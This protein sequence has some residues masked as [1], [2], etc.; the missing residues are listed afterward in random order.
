MKFGTLFL[1][2]CVVFGAVSPMFAN[3]SV[4]SR[5][6]QQPHASPHLIKGIRSFSETNGFVYTE[7]DILRTVDAGKNWVNVGPRLSGD[8]VIASVVFTSEMSIKV[9]A[10]DAAKRNIELLSSENG[11]SAWSRSSVILP[12]IDD[13]EIVIASAMLDVSNGL[14]IE[15]AL[16]T[17]SN[18][19]GKIVY[20][21]ADGETW[22][23]ASRSI[24]LRKE[25]EPFG[26]VRSGTWELRTD[27]TCAG[28]KSGCVQET[29]LLINGIDATPAIIKQ[30]T[31]ETKEAANREAVP[32]FAAPGG[33]TRISLNRGFDKCT[34]GT[35]SQMQT[36]WDNSFHHNANIYMSGRNRACAQPQLTAAWVE[37]VTQM[38]WGLIPTIVGYQAPCTASTTTAKLSTDPV[39][40]EQQGR[41]E[42]DIA[43]TDAAALGITSGSVLYYDMERY[44]DVSGTGACSTPVKAFL[45]GWT[46]RLKEE[47]FISGVY[48]SPKNAQEDWLQIPEASRMDAIW[49]ARWD[50]VMDVWTYISFPTFPTDEWANHQRIKQWQAP[51]DET[52]GGVTFNIDGNILDAPVAG[53]AVAKNKRADFDGDGR[54]DVSVFRFGDNVWHTLGSSNGVYQ[55]VAFGAAGDIGTP[56]DYDGDGKTDRA[57]F[58]PST[59]DWYI[60]KKGF[61]YTIDRFGMDG[62]IPVAADYNGDGETDIAVYRP[63]EGVW[64]I[65]N[66][67][68]RHTFSYYRFGAAE[69]LPMPGDF[70]GDGRDDVAVW[71]PSTGYWYI[72]RSSDGQIAIY[73]F[74]QS[75]DK[76]LTGD[77]DGDGRTDIAVFRSGTWLIE[78]SGGGSTS[79]LFGFGTDIPVA[80]DYDGDGKDDIAVF[81]PETGVW[82]IMASTGGFSGYT[83]GMDG[84]RPVPSLYF[85][86]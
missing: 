20:S 18:F 62:D 56:G 31:A 84:D 74:G 39:V 23:A 21:S 72:L 81:R 42:A 38:G 73:A 69:D 67:D 54:T 30:R 76:P 6:E 2:I 5:M 79:M 47:G 33:T 55:A 45:K 15:F 46:D 29:E 65:A 50:N 22:Q 85:P 9:L 12:G 34:A 41:G 86:Q 8:E 63:S 83:F 52:W 26:G 14:R 82:Y 43:M 36:W 3:A 17:S 19:E 28:F 44:D 70:D 80:G 78:N 11:G 37:Q 13:P 16:Q 61:N 27:G 59:G 77:F 32:R 68:S 35:V 60:L 64:Y 57:V 10:V 24:D 7:K 75:G 25:T 53:L 48:G 58:R 1:V 4:F 51:H 71:R 40:A 66:S 49:M